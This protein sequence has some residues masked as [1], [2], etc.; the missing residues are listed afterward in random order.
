MEPSLKRAS[1]DQIVMMVEQLLETTCKWKEEHNEEAE[2]SQKTTEL[3]KRLGQAEEALKKTRAE[4]DEGL[5]ASE[6]LGQAV[7][8]KDL[9]M[10]KV[11]TE[12]TKAQAFVAE[13]LMKKEELICEMAKV[14]EE[15]E[16]MLES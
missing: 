15:V 2:Q 12:L 16:S 1:I 4:R 10:K 5:R 3:T 14:K 11:W 6:E 8:K 13:Y 7:A 9:D